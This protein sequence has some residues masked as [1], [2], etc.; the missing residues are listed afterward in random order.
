VSSDS[1][2]PKQNERIE[3][4]PTLAS[5]DNI[6]PGTECYKHLL[7]LMPDVGQIVIDTVTQAMQDQF[8]LNRSDSNATQNDKIII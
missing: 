1:Y 5:Q 3:E 2:T 8:S 4:C 7:A 6:K